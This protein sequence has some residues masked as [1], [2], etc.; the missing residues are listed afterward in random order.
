MNGT[1]TGFIEM[2][3]DPHPKIFTQ[4]S[5]SQATSL[6][7]VLLVF[8]QKSWIFLFAVTNKEINYPENFIFVVVILLFTLFK[9]FLN[10]I[11]FYSKHDTDYFY[12]SLHESTIRF[13][14][15]YFRGNKAPENVKQLQISN[16]IPHVTM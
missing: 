1:E 9:A 12:Y 2:L 10:H 11:T 3:P 8:L 13:K 6:S 4:R 5:E 7:N 15:H 16:K 14:Y